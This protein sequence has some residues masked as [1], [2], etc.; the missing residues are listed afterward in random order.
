MQRI[1]WIV[2]TKKAPS[3]AGSSIVGAIDVPCA[4]STHGFYVHRFVN[5]FWRTFRCPGRALPPHFAQSLCVPVRCAL[6][7][8]PQL[9]DCSASLISWAKMVLSPNSTQELVNLSFSSASFKKYAKENN[10]IQA[11]NS[12]IE[13]THFWRS[14]GYIFSWS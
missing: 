2:D 14:L 10:G 11:Y 7:V 13:E 3:A 12:Y 6:C 8:T 1:W 9:K 5:P 4:V